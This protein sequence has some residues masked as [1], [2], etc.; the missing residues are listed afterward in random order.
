MKFTTCILLALVLAVCAFGQA[1]ATQPSISTSVVPN[2]IAIY[3]QYNQLATTASPW[4]G[5]VAGVYNI[6]QSAG[7]FMTTSL[8][9][10][11]KKAIDPT[12]GKAFYALSGAAR[13]GIHKI[14]VSTGKVTFAVGADVGPSFA[15][16][17]GLPSSSITVSASSSFVVT[18][19]IKASS[20]VGIVIPL[21]MLYVSGIGWNPV[22]EIG[23]TI[24]L[25]K[26]PKA[27]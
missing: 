1:A 12:T 19:F 25:G 5:G 21:R 24:N 3:G 7:L 22:G 27:K 10:S 14:A 15:S 4:T 17:T 6:S 20:A 23:I 11:P 2:S 13:Q 16:P 26:L 9:L 18:T 8:D